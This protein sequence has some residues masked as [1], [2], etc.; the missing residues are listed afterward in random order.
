MTQPI[1]RSKE[2]FKIFKLDEHFN[3]DYPKTIFN[4]VGQVDKKLGWPSR[5]ELFKKKVD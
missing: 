2:N 1:T 5:K 4:F 3:L